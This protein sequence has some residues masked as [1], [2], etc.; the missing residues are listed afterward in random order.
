MLKRDREL[1]LALLAIVVATG[2]YA[3][4]YRM[5]GVFP[6]ASGLVGH[7]IGILGF[8]LMLLTEFAYSIR[9]RSN[10]SRLGSMATWLRFHIFT[11]LVGPYLVLLHTAMHFAGLA[12]V[13]MLFTGIV[14]LSGVIGRYLY[15]AVPREPEDLG[16]TVV[17]ELERDRLLASRKRMATWYALHVPLTLVLFTLATTHAVV[18]LLFATLQR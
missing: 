2:L 3:L 9:K 6:R 15:T 16:G 7:G 4:A 14:V 18:A 10:D 13:T 1:Y 8:T 12:G 5:D 11:G 17:T